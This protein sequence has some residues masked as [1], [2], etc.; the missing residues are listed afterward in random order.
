MRLL[1]DTHIALWAVTDSPRLPEAAR[2]VILAPQNEVWI[3]AASIWEISIKY[4]LGRG[5]MPIS[6]TEAVHWFTV[7]GYRD[8]SITATHA[9][10]VGALPAIHRD[11]F[12][13]ILIAQA[14][15]EPLRLVTH[16]EVIAQYSDV[17]MVV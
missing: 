7:S 9:A 4:A 8:L 12:D 15:T 16:D 13:R 5:G 17:V 14:Q 1:L 3:S 11:P 2:S 10:A 6:G